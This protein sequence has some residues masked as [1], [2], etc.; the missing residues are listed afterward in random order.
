MTKNTIYKK[1]KS[2]I[3]IPK[4]ITSGTITAILKDTLLNSF[5]HRVHL[6][7]RFN[8]ILPGEKKLS[9]KF[10]FVL[11]S[12]PGSITVTVRSLPQL[13]HHLT[14][15]FSLLIIKMEWWSGGAME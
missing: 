9:N 7:L 12:V 1:I 15:F 4:V 13:L 14:S 8:F 6:Y 3:V 5:K 10:F 2:I 11:F